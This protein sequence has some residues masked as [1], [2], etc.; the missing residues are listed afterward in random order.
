MKPLKPITVLIAG[1]LLA[2]V[3]AAIVFAFVGCDTTT[4]QGIL[5][6]F[7]GGITL[8]LLILIPTAGVEIFHIPLMRLAGSYLYAIDWYVS[9]ASA[10]AAGYALASMRH[11]TVDGIASVAMIFIMAGA[12]LKTAMHTLSSHLQQSR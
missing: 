8:A 5:A 11:H 9:L 6:F 10:V 12:M 4:A 3:A 2:G 7:F 1:P